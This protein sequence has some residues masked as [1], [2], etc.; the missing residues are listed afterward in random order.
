MSLR[1]SHARG[2][3]QRLNLIGGLS[4]PFI[5]GECDWLTLA[6]QALSSGLRTVDADVARAEERIQRSE[7]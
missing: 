7:F 6:S 5:T 1:E 3:T 4:Q 2:G